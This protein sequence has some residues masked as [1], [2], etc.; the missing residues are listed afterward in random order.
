[1][2]I[3]IVGLDW[4]MHSPLSL[5]LLQ[6]TDQHF[7]PGLH[8]IDSLRST[9]HILDLKGQ[10][11]TCIDIIVCRDLSGILLLTFTVRYSSQWEWRIC[12][13]AYRSLVEGSLC[14]G[15]KSTRLS[16]RTTAYRLALILID[17]ESFVWSIVSQRENE[18]KW[19]HS[20]LLFFYLSSPL[21]FCFF[22]YH[23]EERFAS[24]YLR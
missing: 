1:M 14:N 20:I 9:S 18:Y 22:F 7:C 15:N 6:W 4:I 13:Y 5:A 3:E 21:F 8:Y 2:N 19:N 23:R 16:R 24:K 10:K 11:C 12:K 17:F